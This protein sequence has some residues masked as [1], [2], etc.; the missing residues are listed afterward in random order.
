MDSRRQDVGITSIM[1]R[2]LKGLKFMEDKYL[3]LMTDLQC[4]RQYALVHHFLEDRN[5]TV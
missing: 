1:G 2:L 3:L 5:E 4:Q